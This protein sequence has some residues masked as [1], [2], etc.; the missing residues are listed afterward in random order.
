MKLSTLFYDRKVRLLI[1]VIAFLVAVVFLSIVAQPTRLR[2][3][4]PNL[5]SVKQLRVQ[6]SS[7]LRGDVTIGGSL[8]AGDIAADSLSLGGTP[9]AT[10]TPSAK[11]GTQNITGSATA[12]HGFATPGAVSLALGQDVTAD[13][14]ALTYTSNVSNSV[15]IKV[16]KLAGPTPNTTPAAV[17][18]CV[19]SAP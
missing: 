15:T 5:F 13:A 7:D 1:G 16:W 18:W 10:A 3:Q 11:C 17:S 8:S 4:S 19:R 12:V 2:A 6:Q 9:Y 14:Y